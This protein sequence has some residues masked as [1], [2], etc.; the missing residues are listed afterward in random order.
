MPYGLPLEDA[1]EL[2]L[3]CHAHRATFAVIG[4]GFHHPSTL[5]IVV[6]P[7]RSAA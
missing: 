6:F 7:E 3:W 4:S 1:V 2:V 5:A